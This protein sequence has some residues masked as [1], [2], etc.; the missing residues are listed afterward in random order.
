MR[1][2]LAARSLSPSTRAGYEKGLKKLAQYLRLQRNLSEPGKAVNWQGYFRE[3]PDWLADFIRAYVE[4]RSRNWHADNRV[5]L[6]R[7]LLA[8]LCGFSRLTQPASLVD[9][10]PKRWFAYLSGRMK[11]G[12]QPSTLNTLL[13][14]LQSFLRFHQDS[15][16]PIC[17]RML[18]ARPQKTG[19]SQP[20]DVPIPD[21]KALLQAELPPFDRA[22]LLLTL[23]PALQVQ[24]CSIPACERAKFAG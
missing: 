11:A 13:W 12:I 24:V 1:D 10:T 6:T 22:W 2:Y 18:D 17:E 4:Y 7:N 16:Q 14:H 23:A 21:I 9:I 8:Q 5:Q 19:P 20:R 15:G 3:I